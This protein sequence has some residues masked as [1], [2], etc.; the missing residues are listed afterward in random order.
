LTL[1]LA[2]TAI[3]VSLFAYFHQRKELKLSAV[4]QIFKFLSTD[5]AREQR[6]KIFDVYQHLYPDGVDF[7]KK[8]GQAGKMIFDENYPIKSVIRSV[9]SP[10]DQAGVLVKKG[11][12]D[13][14]LFFDMYAMMVLRVWKVLEEDIMNERG[15]N[16]EVC[17]WFMELKDGAEKYLQKEG[18]QVPLP[19]KRA[20]VLSDED[21]QGLIHPK[22]PEKSS[23]ERIAEEEQTRLKAKDD[24]SQAKIGMP[25]VNYD[26]KPD[27]GLVK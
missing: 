27:D 10:F 7:A 14:E 4:L 24:Y 13:S 26:E 5:E 22:L 9:E 2:I 1:G 8:E 16:E 18:I 25:T 3:I 20:N 23:M 15:R 11:M 21:I 6:G 12:I 19:Y 17:K